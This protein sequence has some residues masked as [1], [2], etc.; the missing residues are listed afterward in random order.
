MTTITVL[1]SLLIISGAVVLLISIFQ[2]KKTIRLA[3]DL[4]SSDKKRIH[5]LEKFHLILMYFFFL[6]YLAMSASLIA[7]LHVAGDIF[8]ALI[9]FGGSIFVL[10]G[11]LLQTN[12]LTSIRLHH[13]EVVSKNK[14]LI[15][16]EDVTIFAL[17]YQAE[18]RD[19]D[20]G[21]HLERSAEYV[22]V[23]AN[24]LSH[25]PK[26]RSQLTYE[27]I[28][29]IVRA[30]PLHDIGKVGV[31][32]SILNKQGKLTPEEFESIK[33]HCEYGANIL[34]AAAKKLDFRLFLTVSIEIIMGHH[35]RWDGSGYP[36]GLKE[37]EIPLCARIMALAD[38]YDALTTKRCYKDAISH[39]ETCIIISN[40]KG[41]QFDP[42]VTEAFLRTE[43]EFLRISEVMADQ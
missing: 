21:K 40:E 13:D 1:A 9:F 18:I 37:E 15:Q 2:Y 6:G 27:Y 41:K 19:P 34:N 29:E 22:K 4:L 39:K 31:P 38:V 24:E 16:T 30:A 8:T 33:K 10:I 42:D 26:Y 3:N 14:Q 25:L 35:E 43:K 23:L 7:G 20:T 11:I 32:D 12:M 36:H 28:S 5:Q 17:A